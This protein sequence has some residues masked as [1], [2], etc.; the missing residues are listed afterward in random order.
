VITQEQLDE[1]EQR[2]TPMEPPPCRVCG[3][4]LGLADTGGAYRG[5]KWACSSREAS[6]MLSGGGEA[7][8]KALAHYQASRWD[9]PVSGDQAVVRLIRAYREL[10]AD[11]VTAVVLKNLRAEIE[12]DPMDLI[13]ISGTI[14]MERALRAIDK[15]LG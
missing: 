2:Y 11:G 14:I 10:L 8:D 9:E 15:R 5:A 6:M 3:A 7:Y 4:E 13:G 1:L 12:R